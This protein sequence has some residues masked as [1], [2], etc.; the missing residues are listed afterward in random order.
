MLPGGVGD[1]GY[2]PP[3]RTAL[4]EMLGVDIPIVGFNRSPDEHIAFVHDLLE[5]YGI[6]PAR[7]VRGHDEILAGFNPA[8]AAALLDVASSTASR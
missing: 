7:E 5:R 2:D 1:R 6:P 8:G 4:T 3:M